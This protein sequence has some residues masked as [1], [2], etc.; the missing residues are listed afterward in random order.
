M[1][2]L[3]FAKSDNLIPAIAQDASTGEVLMLAYLS[4]ESWKLTL[5]TGIAH[6]WSRSRNKLWKK[7]ESSGNVQKISEIRVDCDADTVVLKVEQVGGAA[8]HTGYRSCFYRIVRDGVL[9]EEGVPLFD[10]E[11]VYHGK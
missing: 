4:P 7:G 5:E 10:P 6:Y 11:A 2:E 1:I 8:C 9:V 3:A